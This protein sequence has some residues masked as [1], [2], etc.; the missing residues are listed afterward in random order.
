MTGGEGKRIFSFQS[1]P[2]TRRETVRHVLVCAAGCDFNP[3]PPHG[4]RRPPA[5]LWGATEKFQSTPSAWRETKPTRIP[6]HRKRISIHS[7]R[8]EGDLYNLYRK[9]TPGE[10]QSTPS[11]WRE[12]LGATVDFVHWVF[13]S[14]PSVWRETV[15]G[16]SGN[17][18]LNISIHSLRMEGDDITFLHFD[19][20]S[21]S[22][23]SLRMEGDRPPSRS[24]FSDPVF[25]ST[26]SVWRETIASNINHTLELSFQSTPSAWRET[27]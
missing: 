16:I 12:T 24:I 7:L 10:F 2:S 15:Y 1:T 27:K 18:D 26:P 6:R 4:G 8:M 11:V 19:V 3:L 20:Q 21:I 13:Q 22:I 5:P 25:Q 17:V 9:S 14:T 23:H